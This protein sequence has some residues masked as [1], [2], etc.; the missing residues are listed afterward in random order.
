MFKPTI[1]IY[2]KKITN[3]FWH[4]THS[5]DL[6]LQ[7]FLCCINGKYGYIMSIIMINKVIESAFLKPYCDIRTC[8]GDIQALA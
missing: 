7:L 3:Y 2:I 8:Y 4:Y 1:D 6:F 5:A